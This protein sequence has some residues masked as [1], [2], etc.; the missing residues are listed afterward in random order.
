MI[1]PKLDEHHSR[2]AFRTGA[3]LEF[4]AGHCGI[5]TNR[6]L[7]QPGGKPRL[8]LRHEFHQRRLSARAV[9]FWQTLRNERSE[10]LR[11]EAI[12]LFDGILQFESAGWN[13]LH[14]ELFKAEAY[15]GGYS[16]FTDGLMKSLTSAEGTFGMSEDLPF[17]GIFFHHPDHGTLLMAVLSQDRCKPVWSLKTVGREVRLTASEAYAGIPSIPVAAGA[18]FSHTGRHPAGD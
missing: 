3:G 5:S 12:T 9:E 6:G 11:I 13:V 17:P 16:F 15:F 14:A 7:S 10:E 18:S 8:G 1:E 4:L 2:I